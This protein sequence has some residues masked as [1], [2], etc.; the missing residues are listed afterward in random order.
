MSLFLCFLYGFFVVPVVIR[1]L[2]TVALK[3]AAAVV[4]SVLGSAVISWITSP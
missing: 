1:P 2:P 4:L 3:I